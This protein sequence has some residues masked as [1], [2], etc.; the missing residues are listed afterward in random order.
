[1]LAT[2]PKAR[3][4]KLVILPDGQKQVTSG[5]TSHKAIVYDVKVKIGGVAGLLARVTG[6]QPPD[7]YVW[8]LTGEAP[9]F[10]KSEGPLCEGSPIWRI[11]LATPSGSP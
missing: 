9:A 10:V 3:L 2:T 7:T 4:V 6:K 11:E 1:M 5:N 8:I